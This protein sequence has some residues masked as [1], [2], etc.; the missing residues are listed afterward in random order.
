MDG[1]A[2]REGDTVQFVQVFDAEKCAPR[3]SPAASTARY[4]APRARRFDDQIASTS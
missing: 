1:N 2:L 4:N 3:T